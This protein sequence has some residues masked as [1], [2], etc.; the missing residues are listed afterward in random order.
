[1]SKPTLLRK[2]RII[3]KRE[4]S[5][6]ELNHIEADDLLLEFINDKSITKLFKKI[7]KWYS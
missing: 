7:N 6:T 5:D 2:L 3:L 1:M 4:N